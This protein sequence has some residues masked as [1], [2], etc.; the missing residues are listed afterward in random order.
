MKTLLREPLVHFLV[1]GTLLFVLYGYWGDD[2]EFDKAQITVSSA[3]IEQIRGA[4]KKQWRRPPTEQELQN[5][6]E[7]FIEEEV[8]YREALA[9]GL[10]KD[11]IIVRRRLAQ[12]M[13]FLIQDIADQSQPNEDQLKAF[14]EATR[15]PYRMPAR[16]SF[17]HVYFSP[18]RRDAAV[19]KDARDAL[20]KLKTS[21]VERAPD[22]GDPFMLHHDYADI[23][24]PE[25]ARLFGGT[26]ADNIFG[27]KPG[28]WQG[29][30]RS[31]YGVHL[32]RVSDYVPS[33]VPEFAEVK[34]RVQ[35]AYTNAQRRKAN[36][37]AIKELKVRYGIVIDKK[38]MTSRDKQASA[39]T[40]LEDAP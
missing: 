24:R 7:K 12:K 39:S 32:V 3:Q 11:D 2:V 25:A 35:Q 20:E 5:L 16:V 21:G 1:A 38:A 27:L 8:L 6:I 29:P 23:S 9:M 37:A 17:T 31:G 36:K 14:Y 15:E 34:E 28:Q 10:E 33:R 4:W 18:D 13:R 26:F 30:I 19:V 22:R 40:P